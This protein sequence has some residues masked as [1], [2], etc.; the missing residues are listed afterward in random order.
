MEY[1]CDWQNPLVTGIGREKPHCTLFPAPDLETARRNARDFNPFYKSLNGSW[2]FLYFE[3]GDCPEEFCLNDSTEGWDKLDVPSCWQMNGYDIPQYTNVTFPIPLDP[4]F[5]PDDNPVGLYRRVFNLSKA[6]LEGKIYLTFDGVDSAYYVYL[7]GERVGFSKVSRMPAEFD[8]TPFAQE[9]DNLLTV[10]V[11]KWCDGTYLEDQ[12]CWRVSGIFRDVYLMTVPACHVTDIETHVTL[13]NDYK[14]GVLEANISAEGDASVKATLYYKGEEIANKPVKDGKVRFEVKDVKAWTA[15]TPERYE[16]IVTLTKGRKAVEVSRVMVGFKTV[17]LSP[18]GL[19]INGVSVKLRGVNRHDTNLH[20]GHV[21]PYDTLVKDVTLMKQNN[22]NCVRTSHYPNDPRFLDLCDEYGLYVVD[23]TD[24][25]C[26][27]AF[28]GKWQ[29]GCEEMVYDFSNEPLWEKA[30]VDRAERMVKRDINHPSIIFWSL[31]NESYIGVNHEKMYEKIRSIDP[32][33]PIHYEGDRKD[34][35]CTD[36]ISTMY[37]SVYELIKQGSDKKADKAYFMCEYAHA[38]GLGPGSIK[39]YWETIYKYPRLIGGCVW[40]WVDHGIEVMTEDGEPYYAYGG[41]FGDWP[42][43]NNF[44]VDALNYPDRTP[45][46]GLKNL[47]EAYAPVNFA[48]ENGKIAIYNRLSFTRLDGYVAVWTLLNDGKV[49]SSGILPLTGIAP[50][51]KKTV[52]LPVSELPAGENILDIR[53]LQGSETALVKAG[54][55]VAHTQLPLE[56]IPNVTYLSAAAMPTLVLDG[57]TVYGDEFEIGFDAR[58]GELVYF[59]H[60]ENQLI[61]QPMRANFFRAFTDNDARIKNK[62]QGWKLDHMQV[63]VRSFTIEKTAPSM[64]TAKAVHVHMS[65]NVKPLIETETTWTVFGNGD[66]RVNVA[67]KPLMTIDP[68]LPR[69][70]VQLRMPGGYENLTWYGRGPMESYPDLKLA[71]NVGIYSMPVDDTHEPYVRP[72]EN[73]AHADTRAFAVTDEL[74]N[75]LMFICEQAGSDGFS[76]SCHDYTDEALNEAKHQPELESA[77]ETVVSIDWRQ[78]GI[79]SNSCGPEPME[80]YKLRLEKPETLSFVMRYFRA[81]NGDFGTVM[82]VLPEK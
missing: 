4:P 58:K 30:Y 63:K 60:D 29:T 2:D 36:L 20:L 51:K 34:H 81:G 57:D 43:D 33:R 22:V 9:G 62:W 44:C 71:A 59:I 54:F 64:V 15:E 42:N 56:N 1:T 79:G 26:H 13:K 28:H 14:D 17:E 66:V 80:E 31:G 24:L 65:A 47:R 76:F 73:G 3:D 72:Q 38:M 82:R 8:I 75:G 74:N 49:M 27:G 78:G 69:V 16:L 45:H 19:F 53:V 32:T 18:K 5:V 25:E 6:Q 50:L 46:T 77:G 68:Y 40:E 55:E 37:P 39:E 52:A 12:D 67:F 41:D 10:K 35:R 23:E 70:G 7:N 48:L 11:L 61:S 21:T